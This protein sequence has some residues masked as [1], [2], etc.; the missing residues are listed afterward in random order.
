MFPAASN[1]D[2]LRALRAVRLDVTMPSLTA[3][4]S[5]IGMEHH[6]RLLRWW[7]IVGPVLDAATPERP[8]DRAALRVVAL[9]LAAGLPRR[10]WDRHRR[11]L[12]SAA[13]RPDRGAAHHGPPR[14][15]GLRSVSLDFPHAFLHQQVRVSLDNHEALK[16]ATASDPQNH[17]EFKFHNDVRKKLFTNEGSSLP[18]DVECNDTKAL[19]EECLL[20]VK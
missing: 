2:L 14:C 4:Q 13:R 6:T 5:I 9:K 15:T 19:F 16:S 18:L 12:G 8:L 3:V 7:K 11:A 17:V 20:S 1:T 10:G